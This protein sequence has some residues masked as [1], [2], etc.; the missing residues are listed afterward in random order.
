M[1]VKYQCEYTIKSY[2]I[3]IMHIT[4]GY[5][6]KSFNREADPKAMPTRGVILKKESSSGITSTSSV[7]K[8]LL[9][10]EQRQT[11]IQLK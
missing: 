2:L 3:F 7:I 6:Q 10:M 1:Q 9:D 5:S 11:G 4:L 8:M